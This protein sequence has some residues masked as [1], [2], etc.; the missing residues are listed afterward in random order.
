MSPYVE[1]YII[2]QNKSCFAVAPQVI[3]SLDEYYNMDLTLKNLLP[4]QFAGIITSIERDDKIKE[5]K[6]LLGIYNELLL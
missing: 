4:K 3:I 5:M 2:D 1:V 6:L